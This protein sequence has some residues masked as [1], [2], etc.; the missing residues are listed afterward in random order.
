MLI[1]KISF[2]FIRDKKSTRR[3]SQPR[4][5]YSVLPG[6]GRY[7][8]IHVHVVVLYFVFTYIQ[9]S[10]DS[11]LQFLILK[12]DIC[13]QYKYKYP[14]NIYHT[15][16]FSLNSSSC[17][18]KMETFVKGNFHEWQN[19][20]L[21]TGYCNILWIKLFHNSSFYINFKQASAFSCRNCKNRHCKI[22]YTYGGCVTL[23]SFL[24]VVWRFSFHIFLQARALLRK[25]K[26]EKLEIESANV[27]RKHYLGWRVRK[28]YQPRFRRIAGPK[29]SRFFVIALVRIVNMFI[30]L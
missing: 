18:F 8:M 4:L 23:W 5:C 1:V 22:I 10:Y 2:F 17:N 28:E 14:L 27:I 20:S 29:I 30:M 16:M 11:I 6:V 15:L 25:L 26:R 7:V 13:L 19:L 12:K 9:I 24:C 3:P 21:C